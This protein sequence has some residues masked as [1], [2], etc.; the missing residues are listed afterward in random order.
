[1]HRRTTNTA[2]KPLDPQDLSFKEKVRALIALGRWPLASEVPI[3]CIFGCLLSSQ[4]FPIEDEA[5]MSGLKSSTLLASPFR[6][7]DPWTALQCALIVAGTN[8]SINYGNEY[9]DYDMDRPGMVTSIM[10]DLKDRQRL[11][12][13]KDD[14]KAKGQSQNEVSEVDALIE[15][16]ENEKIM[17]ST[18]RII[19][20][21]TFPP[22]TSLLCSIFVQFLLLTLIV[23]SRHFDNYDPSSPPALMSSGVRQPISP[24]RGAA[25]YLGLMCTFLSHSYVG[26]PLRL[27]Y[28]GFGELISA[29]FLSPVSVLFGLVGHYTAVSGKPLSLSDLSKSIYIPF[30]RRPSSAPSGSG[31]LYLDY[32]LV[33]LLVAFYVYEQ[34]RI[35]IMHIH[36]INADRRGG[37]ITM[38]VRLGFTR[39]SRLYV[40]LNIVAV[41][42]FARL[43]LQFGRIALYGGSSTNQDEHGSLNR[44]AGIDTTGLAARVRATAWV[45][46][47]LSVMAFAIPI[48]VITARSLFAIDPSSRKNKEAATTMKAH[49]EKDSAKKADTVGERLAKDALRKGSD[50]ADTGMTND[51]S[52]HLPSSSS[53]SR[54]GMFNWIPVLPHEMLAKIVSLQVLLTPLVLSISLAFGVDGSLRTHATM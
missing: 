46:G 33:T 23:L 11:E 43:G 44:V 5:D 17:G 45:A 1:M 42:L 35:L 38:T 28:N 40:V 31:G 24:F 30:T 49:R 53:S 10:R 26:P 18:T 9:F 15:S 48:M 6:H 3:W 13:K 22:Y 36:D 29:L 51:N 2:V 4:V 21:G 8:I 25:L 19:H 27:H 47:F 34:A 12:A 14:M 54:V 32:Q 20:D 16:R 7:F 37:K 52:Q 50:A 41:A 39:A